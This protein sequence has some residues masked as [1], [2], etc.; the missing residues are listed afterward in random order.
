MMMYKPGMAVQMDRIHP[1]TANIMGDHNLSPDGRD[2]L[3]FLQGSRI[4]A[5]VREA[6]VANHQGKT[7]I[8]VG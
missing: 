1:L 2:T 6:V 5:K 8:R 3:Q 7:A 4:V